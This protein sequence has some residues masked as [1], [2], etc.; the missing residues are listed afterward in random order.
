MTVALCVLQRCVFVP[1]LGVQHSAGAVHERRTD[2]QDH[3]LQAGG[4]PD[5]RA[6]Q[7]APH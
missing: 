2:G 4:V 6:G 7:P 1:W 3:R 5:L